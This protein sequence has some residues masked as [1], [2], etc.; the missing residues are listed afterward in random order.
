M[1]TQR[2]ETVYEKA[3]NDAYAPLLERVPEKLRDDKVFTYI[4]CCGLGWR[5][6]VFKL[7]DEIDTIWEGYKGKKGRN[8]W[9]I[10]QI[11]EKFGLL[12]Y[13]VE[14]PRDEEDASRRREK[15]WDVISAVQ[16][17]SARICE[18]C[19]KEGHLVTLNLYMATV[20]SDCAA[21][22]KERSEK[23]LWPALF[24]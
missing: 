1:N 2:E 14:C 3:R 10:H 6:I 21:R 13:Y 9:E 15:T 8:C 20:C 11:K 7:T 4:L 5:E 12:R 22:W 16:E 24:G 17:A 18:R 19:G 23:G